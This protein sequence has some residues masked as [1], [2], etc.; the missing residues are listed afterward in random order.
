MVNLH[1]PATV[2][3]ENDSK[4]FRS[5]GEGNSPLPYWNSYRLTRYF[6]AIVTTLPG[7]VLR[8]SMSTKSLQVGK[9]PIFPRLPQL[10]I[11][12]A[13]MSHALRSVVYNSTKTLH[14]RI[15]TKTD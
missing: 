5:F 8:Q 3:Q 4:L 2:L 14:G 12:Q 10:P 11:V 15:F 9:Q 1:A 6:L 7:L 13:T